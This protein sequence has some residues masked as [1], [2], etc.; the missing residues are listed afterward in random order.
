MGK[1]FVLNGRSES[2]KTTFGKIV[3]EELALR[4]IN[5]VHTSS[6]NLVKT[7][8]KPV[9][10][11]D[12]PGD[13]ELVRSLEN[14]KW[15]VTQGKDWDGVTKDDY[16]RKAMSDLKLAITEK[17]PKLIPE[18]ILNQI[19]DLPEPFTAFVDMR[20][21][22]NIQTFIRV[23]REQGRRIQAATVF[24]ESDR[25]RDFHNRSDES[26]YGMTY[27]YIIRNDRLK[28]EGTWEDLGLQALRRKACQFI[29]LAIIE[30]RSRP[31]II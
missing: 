2:G 13:Y 27:D 9:A 12:F 21:P 7:I 30:H 18:S 14:L 16:W 29:D 15:S 20:E 10:F 6:I 4:G 31:E 26:V 25:A 5:F 17:Y 19:S 23:C 3:A 24:V 11:W 22:E 28:Y 8:L 1:I